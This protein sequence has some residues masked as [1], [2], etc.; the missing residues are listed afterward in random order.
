MMSVFTWPC[1]VKGAGSPPASWRAWPHYWA[2]H[3]AGSADSWTTSGSRRSSPRPTPLYSK[4]RRS[5][6]WR[7]GSNPSVLGR[8]RTPSGSDATPELETCCYKLRTKTVW[9][10]YL[11]HLRASLLIHMFRATY[12]GQQADL[13][14]NQTPTSANKT[15][16]TSL[17]E[18][19]GLFHNT[20]GAAMF[21]DVTTYVRKSDSQLPE[22]G[23]NG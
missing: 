3:S 11:K 9:Q 16:S 19:P 13:K 20:Q 1:W 17:K 14:I 2:H 18:R 22:R 21:T 15:G 10:L 7:T 8:T 23:K 4:W 6:S 5:P 12:R